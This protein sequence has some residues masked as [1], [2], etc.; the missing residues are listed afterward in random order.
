MKLASFHNPI[1]K[2][3][4]YTNLFIVL[5]RCECYDYL[6]GIAVEMKKCGLDPSALPAQI[7]HS[8]KKK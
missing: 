1:E 8:D 2:K 4:Y 6:F 7:G 3:I 5:I